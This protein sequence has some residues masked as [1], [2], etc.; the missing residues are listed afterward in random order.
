MTFAYPYLLFCAALPILLAIYEW[1]KRRRGQVSAAPKMM[2]GE[3][4]SSAVTLGNTSS[5]KTRRP[6]LRL[7]LYLGL[8][9]TVVALARPQWGRIDEPVFDQSREILLAIDLSRSMLATDV[10]P[11]RLDRAKLLIQ[12][13]LERLAGERV[14]LIVFS[15]TAFLQS[16]LSADYEILREF[17]PELDPNYLPEGGTNYEA[18][19]ATALASFSTEGGADRFMIILSDGEAMDEAWRPLLEQVKAK[20]IRVIGLGIGTSEG[21]MIPDSSGAFVKDERGAVVLSRLE[22]STLRAISEGTDG[23][24]ADASSW[25]DVATL[26][27]NTVEKGAKGEFRETNQIRLAERYQWAL[28][29]AFILLAWS[30][31]KEFPV[32]PRPRPLK[33][34]PIQS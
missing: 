29:P 11:S 7:R 10:K 20:G 21:S 30:F 22:S 19:L 4:G 13:L 34:S 24:Y 15:G 5:S 6:S 32:R 17:L 33:L 31:L 16:P 25:V 28:A 9:L 1:R 3:A 12:S 26:L 2:Y 14:G 8:I 27:Q 23:L 18:L